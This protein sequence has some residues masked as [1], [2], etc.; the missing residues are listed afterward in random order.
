M[1]RQYLTGVPVDYRNKMGRHACQL[2]KTFAWV[3]ESQGTWYMCRA[4][5]Q[6]NLSTLVAFSL[7]WE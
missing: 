6:A 1:F 3:P 5:R 7:K 4:S 2:I